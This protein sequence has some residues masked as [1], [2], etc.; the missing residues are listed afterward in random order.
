MQRAVAHPERRIRV[1]AASSGA[2][3]SPEGLH[4]ALSKKPARTLTAADGGVA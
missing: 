2:G 4:R 1:L 3:V